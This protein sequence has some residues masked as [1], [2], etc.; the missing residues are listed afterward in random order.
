MLSDHVLI[1]WLCMIRLN[2]DAEIPAFTPTVVQRALVAK[3]WLEIDDE[4]DWQGNHQ[5]RWTDAG[6]A[7]SDLGGPEW[8]IET[9]ETVDG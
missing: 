3:G 7:V 2:W 5:A 4:A 6:L 8:G 9:L 1:G